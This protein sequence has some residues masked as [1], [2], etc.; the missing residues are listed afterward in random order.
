MTLT[1]IASPTGV[2]DGP[3]PARPG[4]RADRMSHPLARDV[5]K[6]LAEHHGVCVHPRVFRRVD[7]D[8]GA[9]EV[10]EVPCGA[11]RESQCRPC[12]LR[13]KR[14]RQ[15]QIRDGWH[16]D[17]EPNP[18]SRPA[19]DD[20]LALV[21]ERCQ[22][23]LDTY[24]ST[25]AADLTTLPTLL[26]RI[27]VIDEQ[28]VQLGI[29]GVLTPPPD[30]PGSGGNPVC[31]TTD[32]D[33]DQDHSAEKRRNGKRRS[34]STRR[35]Q[36]APELPRLSVDRRTV[37][38]TYT[39]LD[40]RTHRPSTLLT[41]TLPS[42]GPV[43]TEARMRRDGRHLCAC[44]QMHAAYDPQL[45]TPVDPDSYDYRAAALGAIFYAA[46]MDRFWQNL[47]R[48][49]GWNVQYAGTVEMQ[50]RLAPHGHH[51]V[52]G[53]IPRKLLKAVAAA[54]YHQVWWPQ[55]DRPLYTVDKPPM[56]DDEAQ[57]YMDSRTG[58]RLP[59]WDEALSE[60]DTDD[61]I[62]AHVARLGTV[63]VR[64]IEPGSRKAGKAIGYITKYITK[65]L[66]DTA[67]PTSD[68]QRQH[69]D[70]LH[71]ELA[72]LPCTPACANWLLYGIQPKKAK[73][74]LLPGRCTGKVHQRQTLGYT[75]RRVLI[76]RNWSG[77]TLTDHRHDNRDYIHAV[78][79]AAGV[80]DQDHAE[81]P[82]TG[83][84]Y[85]E[86][87]RTGDPDVPPLQHRL[88]HAIAVRQRWRQQLHHARNTGPPDVPA[89]APPVPA[90]LATAA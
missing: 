48:A 23:Q 2:L 78:L 82:R 72:T 51:A 52:R 87:A 27:D 77:K 1:V 22:L 79:V 37:G 43:H 29:R 10:F 85:Y 25:R 59:T 19:S 56:W 8:T 47:R 30:P 69:L 63:D 61:A 4:S 84:F 38:R 44:G 13:V 40:G 28:L 42:Y 83:R 11:R 66:T 3:E 58:Q 60:L 5:L 88:A 57:S 12:A 17:T 34:R 86:P 36:D 18:I 9:S 41:T 80:D 31:G 33:D 64:G 81:Q 32:A 35:R 45:G 71:A 21:R 70:R 24:V 14:L 7:T 68:P 20:V 15:Q 90:T 65:D 53:T 55:F 26:R 50:K 89:T 76:S 62:P 67:E 16:R 6:A 54:T 39:G 46:T 74:G 49:C 73:E 75:G